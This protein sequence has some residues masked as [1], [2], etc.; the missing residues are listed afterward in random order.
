MPR[1]QRRSQRGS[2]WK[3]PNHDP[4]NLTWLRTCDTKR[5]ARGRPL[6]DPEHL[7]SDD[8]SLQINRY[9]A[10]FVSNSCAT[11]DL[12]GQV[13]DI[14]VDTARTA[15]EGIFEMPYA[16]INLVHEARMAERIFLLQRKC[17]LIFHKVLARILMYEESEKWYPFRQQILDF[18]R[19]SLQLISDFLTYRC[20]PH[21][22]IAVDQR[23]HV[24]FKEL[25]MPF[26]TDVWVTLLDCRIQFDPSS[27]IPDLRRLVM[28]DL[29]DFSMFLELENDTS[30]E[31][32]LETFE[33]KCNVKI[34]TIPSDSALDKMYETIVKS[35]EA[36]L[37]KKLLMTTE[38]SE[39]IEAARKRT[40]LW[41]A[42]EDLLNHVQ[43]KCSLQGCPN[44]ETP[45]K[46][47]TFRCTECYYFHWCSA[48]CRDICNC[49][50]PHDHFKLCESVSTEL[51]LGYKLQVESFLASSD[52]PEECDKES[53][54][55]ACGV[56]NPVNSCGHCLKVHYCGKMCQEWD[57]THGDHKGTC[58]RKRGCNQYS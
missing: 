33:A 15:W 27:F 30:W 7:A 29:F 41:W 55:N 23:R 43:R 10:L 1:N 37:R 17:W 8:P 32:V 4:N 2:Q 19:V 56:E 39:E 31:A 51:K 54:C 52:D 6:L 44:L 40:S 12:V 5:D 42:E 21:K 47:H 13:L 38:L 24:T 57:W 35:R 28:L 9:I 20:P 18:F 3:N 50:P 16:F 53:R 49:Y 25:A 11:T 22:I 34:H 46:P 58:R 36:F 45:D 26:A 48:A 14:W